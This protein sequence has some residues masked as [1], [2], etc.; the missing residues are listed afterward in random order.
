MNYDIK[1]K[2]IL[3]TG[4]NRGIGKAI[5]ESFIKHGAAKV[6]AAVRKLDSV[7]PLVEQY[8]DQVVPIRVD[9]SD[10]QSI[11]AAAQIAKDVQVVVNNA[12]V[13]QA[14]SLLDEDAIASLKFQM[15]INVYGLIY[16]AQAFAPVLKTNGGGVFAQINSVASLK[17]SPNFVTYCASKA[18]AYSITQALRELLNEQGTLVLSVHP[19]PI[20]TDMGDAAGLTEIAEP[21]VLVA[22][23]IIEALKTGN[24][25]VFPDSMA[26]QMGSAYKSFA[27]NVVEVASS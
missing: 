8:G 15:N 27:E 4:A 10:P 6:Y 14:G 26:K 18:A 12:G 5:V 11:I 16:I 20:A 7:S 17:N 23:G 13:F 19:G 9:L 22:E 24:F 3:V 1:D 2:I 21:P 25:H